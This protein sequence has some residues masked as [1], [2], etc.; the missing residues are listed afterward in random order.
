MTYAVW[1]S[2]PTTEPQLVQAF[3][4]WLDAMQHA[5]TLGL[6]RKAHRPAHLGITVQV[7]VTPGD[8]IT[9]MVAMVCCKTNTGV[10]D[11]IYNVK[12]LHIEGEQTALEEA[13]T[14]L[15]PS[16]ATSGSPNQSLAEQTQQMYLAYLELRKRL[17]AAMKRSKEVRELVSK[18]PGPKPN[19]KP[20]TA[21]SLMEKPQDLSPSRLHCIYEYLDGK[22]DI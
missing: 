17:L 4:Y 2:Q 20:K 21:K 14:S 1:E 18:A 9:D 19:G 7:K 10:I 12:P 8:D 16:L 5:E 6:A 11:A 22:V 15:T 13:E 3:A